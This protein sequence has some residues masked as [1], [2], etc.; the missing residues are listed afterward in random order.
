MAEV[1]FE[2]R[3]SPRPTAS[4]RSRCMRSPASIS[5]STRASWSCCSGP[6]AAASRRCSTSWAASTTPT[7]GTVRFRDHDLTALDDDGLTAYRRDH[8]GFVFQFYNLIPSLTARENVDAGD[9]DRARSDAGR[10]GARPASASARAWTTSRRRCRAASSSAWRSRAP[11]P[12]ARTCCC[13]TSRPARSTARPASAC[14]RRCRR[15]TASSAPPPRSSPT[16][17]PSRTWRTACSCSATAA[18]PARSVNATRKPP[19]EISW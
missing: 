16:T 4:A 10:G 13:A 7:S 9:R 3:S 18:S 8:V 11:S 19:S 15:S 2:A 1:V 6:R 14:S 12:S 5:S 17:P